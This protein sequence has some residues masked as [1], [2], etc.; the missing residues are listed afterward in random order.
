MKSLSYM[1]SWLGGA[2]EKD[3]G[4]TFSSFLSS[5]HSPELMPEHSE[6]QIP[7]G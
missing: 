2:K 3:S 5:R 1:M 6:L 4:E 7:P